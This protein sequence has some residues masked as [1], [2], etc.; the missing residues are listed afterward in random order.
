M[1]LRAL[2]RGLAARTAGAPRTVKSFDR[3]VEAAGGVRGRVDAGLR[4]VPVAEV[5][6]SVDRWRTLRPDFLPVDGG[7][8]TARHRRVAEAMRDGRALP[9]VELYRLAP[10]PPGGR[11][12]Y[13]V[14]DGHHRVA[15]AR[16]LGQDF[17]DAHV[18][19]YRVAGRG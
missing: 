18:V 9:P 19:E 1:G 11:G 4:V 12:E 7:G 13:Y 5:V 3:A 8:L 10:A 16:R 6:G 15:V 14:V 2:W 17:L